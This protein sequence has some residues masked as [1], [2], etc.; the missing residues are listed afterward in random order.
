VFYR[1]IATVGRVCD[2]LSR[3]LSGQVGSAIVAETLQLL[4]GFCWLDPDSGWFR[5]A[6]MAKHGLPKVIEKVLAVA[7]EIAVGDF[8]AALSRNRRAWG[9]DPPEHVLLAFCRQ[10][11]G[12]RVE[13][14]R[15][16]ADPPLSWERVL[17]GVEAELVRIFLRHGPVMERSRL[18]DLCVSSGM[19]RFSF[20][21]FIACSPVVAQ[22]GHSIYGLVGADV[23]AETIKSL[24]DRRRAKLTPARVL[25]S[26]ARTE[27]GKLRLSYRLSRAASTCAVVTVP[28]ALK[29]VVSGKFRLISADDEHV[30]TLAAKDGRAW[31]LGAF[32][33]NK[34][35]QIGDYLVITFDLDGRT[36]VVSLD[37]S[38]SA[39]ISADG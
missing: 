7:G 3:S 10:M 36:A 11:P 32:L 5:L 17:T 28:A 37:Q 20:H 4:D 18:E 1:G 29:H 12:V 24:A 2:A 9:S 35:A 15:I 27:D 23:S 25:E 33:R 21:A 6:S 39:A 34:G 31:G 26:H 8:R 22:Y 14:A 30:G 19:N 16:L 13:G 38:S